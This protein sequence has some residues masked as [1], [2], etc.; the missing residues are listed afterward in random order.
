ME[1]A[2]NHALGSRYVRI[3]LDTSTVRHQRATEQERLLF[4]CIQNSQES[5]SVHSSYCRRLHP[6]FELCSGSLWSSRTRISEYSA[7]AVID[8]YDSSKGFISSGAEGETRT[9]TTLFG[10]G[11]FKS[12]ASTIPPPQHKFLLS[13]DVQWSQ[14]YR[15]KAERKAHSPERGLSA[16]LSG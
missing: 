12:P 4:S 10:S 13:D 8:S 7:K 2:K 15:K 16:S 3:F 6:C 11:D 14:S 5:P 9:L 1:C